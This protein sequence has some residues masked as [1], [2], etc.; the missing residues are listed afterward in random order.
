MVRDREPDLFEMMAGGERYEMVPLPDSMC[1]T[2]LFVGN[3][4]EF[5]HDED[6][7]Q[8]FQTVSAL[9]SV[10]ACVVRKANMQ[11]LKY[12]FVSFL[13]AEEK[14]A[15]IL[16]FHGSEWRGKRIKVECIRDDPRFGRVRV[17]ESMVSYVSGSLKRTRN[18]KVNTMRTARADASEEL[19]KKKQKKKA[20]AKFK[21]A[22]ALKRKRNGSNKYRLSS[23]DQQEVLRACKKG[24]LTLDGRKA[25]HGSL[26]TLCSSEALKG[27]R[28]AMA[29]R[30][31]C[32]E[33]AKPNIVLYKASGRH[34]REVLDYIVVDLSPLREQLSSKWTDDIMD[35]A[36]LAG[37]ELRKTEDME[38][39]STN[40]ADAGPV[41]KE[42]GEGRQP[43]ADLPFVSMGF[44]VGER[45]KAKA[46][47][48]ELTQLWDLPE[49]EEFN[50]AGE[51]EPSHSNNGRYQ[52][53]HGKTGKK[54]VSKSKDRRRGRIKRDDLELKIGKYLRY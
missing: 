12:G 2:T 20:K 8:L 31:W 27:V 40:V 30:D 26:A 37:M 19:S 22:Q 48:K 34:T 15:A 41:V 35:A 38:E 51:D 43:I 52:N 46:M 25:G 10:P 14:E 21:K 18:G 39:C 3:L 44:F 42:Q 13:T 4:C 17:P 24:Y 49:V 7:S 28:M 32:D 16:R 5:V 50:E 33:R 36:S 1:E 29:H 47:A 6:L 9:Q 54:N 23:E 11:S 53:N 45:S